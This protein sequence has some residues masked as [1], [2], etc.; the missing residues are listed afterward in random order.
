[1][2][3][4]RKNKP[5]FQ[6]IV[7]LLSL[8]L[9]ASPAAYA[10]NLPSGMP[11]GGCWADPMNTLI[12]KLSLESFSSNKAGATASVPY[13]T[14]PTVYSAYCYST[15]GPQQASYSTARMGPSAIQ[16]D[17]SGY[18]KLS[19]DI[20]FQVVIKLF[21]ASSTVPFNDVFTSGA[22]G[23]TG[24]G[25]TT[26]PNSTYGGKGN[27]NFK[28]RRNIIGGAFSIRGGIILAS[29]YRYSTAG[30]V[31]NV[32]VMR[33]VTEA[34]IV[35]IPVDCRI[36]GGNTINVSFGDIDSTK[37]TPSPVSSLYRK[38]IGLQYKCNTTLTQD[39]KVEMVATP[40]T[41]N[42]NAIKTS[43]ADIGIVMTYNDITVKPN[44]SFR[45][46]LQYGQGSDNVTFSV[47]G[48]NGIKPKTGA[49]DGS[50]TLI[51]GSL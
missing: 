23:A 41:F 37:L 3:R 39:I 9:L 35:P 5:C 46:R 24:N 38:E 21:G 26:M 27:I 28:L 22:T 17:T 47:V 18:Y 4:I 51:I 2:S 14:V 48:K 31:S 1:M 8:L 50:A 42:N 10:V 25:I 45:S 6:P 29:L 32:P 43:N 34:S 33:L 16:G 13:Q 19:D 36:N 12:V 20:D 7:K 44:E 11:N 30:A 49:F 15:T 40:A